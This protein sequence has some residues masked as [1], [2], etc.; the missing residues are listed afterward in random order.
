MLCAHKKTAIETPKPIT[1]FSIGKRKEGTIKGALIVVL[2]Y[3][4]QLFAVAIAEGNI[5]S[6]LERA[7]NILL[8]KANDFDMENMYFF[9]PP[10]I[11]EQINMVESLS[12]L[13]YGN[14]LMV[15]FSLM[16]GLSIT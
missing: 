4:Q 11:I 1:G 8:S 2:K 12:T 10:D 13:L 7:L 5:T 3:A 9:M 14:K 16:A 6:T 15:K